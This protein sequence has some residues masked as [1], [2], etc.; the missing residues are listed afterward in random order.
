MIALIRANADAIPRS[1]GALAADPCRIKGD[2]RIAQ[3][4]QSTSRNQQSS[5]R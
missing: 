2:Q 4:G 1:G 5:A 3:S